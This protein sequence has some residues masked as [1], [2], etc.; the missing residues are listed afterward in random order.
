MTILYLDTEFNGF[1]GELLS[2]AL[3]PDDDSESFYEEIEYLVDTIEG[4]EE[5]I[6]QIAN[7]RAEVAKQMGK[8]K[9]IPE[10]AIR[11]MFA[12][13]QAVTPSE[14]FDEIVSV[15]NREVLKKLANETEEPLK[16]ASFD[17][18]HWKKMAGI[19]KG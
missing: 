14:G 10:A 15:D 19:L 6:I 12:S 16:E 3:V 5:L 7:K 8:A 11:R 17:L 2:L 18:N 1:G 13:Y 4:V 9:T